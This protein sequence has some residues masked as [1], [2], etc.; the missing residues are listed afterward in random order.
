MAFIKV[1]EQSALPPGSKKAVKIGET[2]ILLIHLEG[3][4]GQMIAVEAKCP[5][6]GAPLEQGA[7]CDGKLICPW[8]T[9]T[10][11]LPSGQW[12]EPPPL[13][14]L[15]TYPLEMDAEGS[16]LVDP[17][18]SS[19]PTIARD[20]HTPAASGPADSRHFVM[21]GAGAATA[22]AVCTLRQQGFT[23]RLTLV[24]PS[25]DEPIDRTNLSKTA[26]AGKSE[27]SA[28]P[29]WSAED[30]AALAVEPVASEATSLDP[31]AQTVTLA[32][33]AT[34][35]FDAALLATGGEPRK[36][37][38]TGE[39]LPKVHTLR[40]LA[41]LEAIL[42]Q[43]PSED[44]AKKN[45]RVALVGDS[46]IA[47][48]VASALTQR[49]FPVTVI[50]R[51][52]EPFAKKWG[53]DLAEAL[54]TLHRQNGVTLLLGAQTLAITPKTIVLKVGKTKPD[55]AQGIPADLVLV[56]VGVR[57]RTEFATSLP[58]SE[59]EGKSLV[60]VGSDLKAAPTVW[61]AGDVTE[62]N[63][64]HIEHWRVAQ[65]HGRTA[66]LG[67]LGQT[68]TPGTPFF[69]TT[70]F[71]KRFG[72]AG[73]AEAWDEL[74]ID[75]NPAKQDFL[76][77]FVKGGQVAAVLGCGRDTALAML[78]GSLAQGLPLADAQTRAAS[79]T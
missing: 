52:P 77:Y 48:E 63:G 1:L 75:G 21:I 3:A 39:T 66:V 69:W 50:A 26:M 4:A 17:D 74:V 78:E 72:Y 79:A 5:H 2:E 6:A 67:M 16:I 73:H 31:D 14:S 11:A 33:G 25:A 22:A 35:H 62:V 18:A 58:L 70:H 49:G 56:A 23:G 65:Q 10:F 32:N 37:G 64:T 24:D 47:F 51:S 36:L 46:F 27:P 59:S 13:R 45:F 60:R 54:L 71:G 68:V 55:V 43:L 7:I 20:T 30:R 34:L 9:G 19:T 76:S 53:K 61:A 15:K 28:L 8:H 41:D 44:T 40:H 38:V 29:L 42:G 12:L 57:P